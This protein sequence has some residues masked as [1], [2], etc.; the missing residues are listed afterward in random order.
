[1]A[2]LQGLKDYKST[3]NLLICNTHDKTKIFMMISMWTSPTAI[4]ILIRAW[5]TEQSHV[6]H[7]LLFCARVLLENIRRIFKLKILD[8]GMPAFNEYNIIYQALLLKHIQ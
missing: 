4:F 6:K 7:E 8:T 2:T 5:T 3:Q 1:M